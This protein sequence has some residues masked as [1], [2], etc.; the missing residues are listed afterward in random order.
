MLAAPFEIGFD[1]PKPV[2]KAV[3]RPLTGLSFF[4]GSTFPYAASPIWF[5]SRNVFIGTDN[6]RNR[7]VRSQRV[8][9]GTLP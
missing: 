7:Q 2:A 5:E 9:D 3:S 6:I 8:V 4:F 1:C